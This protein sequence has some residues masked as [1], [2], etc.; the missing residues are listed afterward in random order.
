MRKLIMSV[1][2]IENLYVSLE[3]KKILQGLS[4]ELTAGEHIAVLGSGGCGKSTLLKTIIGLIPPQKGSIEIFGENLLEV[5]KSRKIELLQKVGMA[6]QQG[7]LFDFMT[8]KENILFSMENMSKLTLP[9]MENRITEMLAQVNLPHAAGKLPSELSG[10]MRRRVGIVR[11]LC[12]HP[13]L[14]LVDEPTAG[15]DPVTSTIVIDLILKLAD[16]TQSTI[17]CVTSNVDVAFRFAKRV[18]ILFEGRILGFGTWDELHA[19]KN[20][21]LNH[22][23]DVRGQFFEQK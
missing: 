15:L 8:V 21:W 12:T 20:K 10:G 11:A 2:K 1:L 9:E 19:L 7:A 13:R 4:L 18:A 14:A 6:F 16:S 5:S 3:Q 17:V 23:L 22:F